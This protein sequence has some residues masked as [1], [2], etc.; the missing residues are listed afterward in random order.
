LAGDNGTTVSLSVRLPGASTNQ[1]C[2]LKRTEGLGSTPHR[3]YAFELTNQKFVHFGRHPSGAGYIRIES[4]DGRQ[5]I[6]TEFDRALEAL[7]DTPALILDVRG[8]P[9][10]FGTAQPHIVGRFVTNRT[11][12]AI[13]Y[14]KNGPAHRDLE[15]REDFFNP[16]GE[17]QYLQPMALLIDEETG[18]AADLFTCYM[19]STGRVLTIGSPTHGNLS[20]VAAYVV[21]PCG[22]IVRI[23]NGY[24]CDAGGQPIESKGNV[25]DVLVSPTLNDVLSCKD[26]VLEKSAALLQ[27]KFAHAGT[28][29]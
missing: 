11:L 17:W 29:H 4:F 13:S 20:G 21:L 23:S 19:R 18:S 15:R 26:P 27:K 9:G 14:L 5:E 2:S 16:A 25:P 6:A 28:Q 1:T 10:G 12:V 7:K 8:N 24:I 3:T 22:L